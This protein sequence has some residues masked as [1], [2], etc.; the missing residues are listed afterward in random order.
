M[1]G[2]LLQTLY[3]VQLDMPALATD[4]SLILKPGKYPA[5]GLLRNAQVIANITAGH[6]QIKL[7]NRAMALR[8]LLRQVE[9]KGGQAFLGVMLAEQ[10]QFLAVAD[11]RAH[12]L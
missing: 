6:A 1:A 10:Q 4:K 7:G 12:D 9:Q 3:I 8:E 5:H 2:D 11:F